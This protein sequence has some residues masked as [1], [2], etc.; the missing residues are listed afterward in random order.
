M[1][2]V[3]QDNPSSSGEI[4]I[5]L[6]L[7]P[8]G[9]IYF[10]QKEQL[11]AE[12]EKLETLFARDPRIGLLHLGLCDFSYSL[13]STFLF[14][15]NFSRQFITRFCKLATDHQAVSVPFLTNEEVETFLTQAPF[16]R[17]AEYLSQEL[18][19]QLWSELEKALAQELKNFSGGTQ[20]YFNQHNKRWNLI[21]RVCFHLA[22]N[23]NSETHPFAFLATYTTQLSY[24]SSAQHI[25]LKQAI[26]K[27][28]TDK[29]FLLSLLVPVQKAAAS[30]SFINKI[31]E[32]GAVFEA[33][34]WT[35]QEA[36]QF[37]KEIPLLEESGVVVRVPNWWT[38]QKKPRI[39]AEVQIGSKAQSMLG[40]GS[41]FDFNVQL[42]IG[43][44]SLT[45]E[46]WLALQQGSENLVKIKGQWVEIDREKLNAVLSHWNQLKKAAKNG[47]S[48]AEAFR[49][50]AGMDT[51]TSSD[52]LAEWSEIKPGA[53]LET[54][55]EQLKNPQ[56]LPS[57]E[58]CQLQGTL[59][60]YQAKGVHWLWTLYQLKLSGCLAD[61]MGLGKTI[62]VL[63]LL[64]AIK[65]HFPSGKPH[66][67]IVPASLIGNWQA[68]AL[69]FAPSL[70]IGVAHSSSDSS[71]FST[72]DLVITTYAFIHRR[73][74][75]KALDWDLIIL[76]EAQAIKNPSSKQTRSVKALKGQVRL[77]LTGTPVEN[78]LGDLW[79]LFDFL[80]PGLLGSIKEF[81][82]YLKNA[83]KSAPITSLRKLTQPYIL[84]RLKSDKSII[85]DLPDK[86]EMKTY[87]PLSKEQVQHYQKA[88]QELAQKLET[89]EGIHRR[90]LILSS[91]M[92]LKQICNHPAQLQGFGEYN[93][94]ESGKMIRLREICE[95][96]AEKQEKVLI[97]TQFTEVIP[98]LF[99]FLTA[100]FGRE[101]V[102]LDGSTPVKKRAQ[103]VQNFQQEQGPPF[104]ILSLKA[105][106]TGL[107]L[108]KASHV[109][110]F[111]RWWNPAVENQ[112]T[113]R[114]YRIGQKHPVLVHQFICQGTI[115]EKIDALIESK[116]SISKELLE[117]EGEFSVTELSNEQIMQIVSL[118]I[119][120][121]LEEE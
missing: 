99:S 105:G 19:A 1:E 93:E 96:I 34:A 118:D 60:P 35:I 79:S 94:E 24:H 59:R 77:A 119:H 37:L 40:L 18:L 29:A 107:N 26:Q 104:F 47:L 48:M 63:S 89:T 58:L 83:S 106:G 110:H 51:S 109:I 81:S 117:G 46:E 53:W 98:P 31:V 70:K 62:Q 23:K 3:T 82:N 57:A 66:L 27:S 17:G 16:M 21:G 30:S 49:L 15:Q 71:D 44:Q 6:S 108:T 90:G 36:H 85:S 67:L 25:P 13:S 65:H 87:C 115:E 91:L 4:T 121:A 39:K 120:R 113:D 12:L 5:D 50:L 72:A 56:S 20:E 43:D 10:S 88:I 75:L 64:L 28:T 101:G 103:L 74:D 92:R 69:K 55:L 54:V 76:D 78:R 33:T 42:A 111:D 116:K 61:D 84:R 22:E 38:P 68:E 14:W 97:F 45:Q 32:S 102:T 86:T 114:A 11:P 9:H 41:V 100:I 112:A 52:T 95:A 73:E 7:S 8:E 2:C 80:S